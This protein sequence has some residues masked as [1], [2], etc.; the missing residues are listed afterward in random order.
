MYVM[1]LM[2]SARALAR[3]LTGQP[4]DVTYPAMPVMVKT[5]VCPLVVSPPVSTTSGLWTVSGEGQDI[6][7]VFHD[8]EGTLH[9]YALTGAAVSEKLQLNRQLPAWLA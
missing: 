3:T 4:T 2:T 8:A 5:P 6:R 7:A 1:P 9:G